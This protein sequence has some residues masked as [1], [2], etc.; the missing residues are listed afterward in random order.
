MAIKISGSTIIDDSR[1]IVNAGVVTASTVTANEFIGTGDKLIFSPTV[2]S[3]SPTQGEID[4]PLTDNISIT[5]DQLIYAGVGTI[6]L[7][8]SSGIGTIIESIGI[9]STLISGQTLNI[10]PSSLLPDNTNIYVVLPQGVIKNAVDGS[11]VRIDTYNFTTV[12]FQFSSIN[13]P[14]GATNVGYDTAI[15]L[16]FTSPPT[17]GTGTIE[18]RSGSVN[19]S[20]IESFDA[21]SS[22]QITINGNDWILTPSDNLGFSTSIHT[23]IPTNA[24]SQFVGLNTTGATTHSF[25]IKDLELGDPYE[26]GYFICEAGGTRW[27]VAPIEAEVSAT[28]PGTGGA[29]TKAQQC[30]GCTGWFVPAQGQLSNPAYICRQYWDAYSSTIYW[31]ST[32]F[33]ATFGWY[34]NFANG[35]GHVVNKSNVYCARAFRCVSY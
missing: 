16:A 30:T 26:G 11:N 32:Q 33:N 3:F 34:V 21:A 1:N 28:Q 8:N 7:R 2:T 35:G 29:V 4:V 22:G 10:T 6:T 17:R 15:T 20:L 19:G 18:L 13:P 14:N 12:E 24:I 23:I 31:T 27:I 5:F 9:G 25:T